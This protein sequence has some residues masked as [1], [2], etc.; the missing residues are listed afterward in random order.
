[1]GAVSVRRDCGLKNQDSFGLVKNLSQTYVYL[2]SA[3]SEHYV[4]NALLPIITGVAISFPFPIG[5]C[6][7]CA[8]HLD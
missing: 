8:L 3:S 6:E 5:R 2:F 1:M 7:P 4:Y